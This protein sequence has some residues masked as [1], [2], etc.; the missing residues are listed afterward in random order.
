MSNMSRH[1]MGRVRPPVRTLA[2]AQVRCTACM[3]SSA[4]RPMAAGAAA[5]TSLR[6]RRRDGRPPR[7]GGSSRHH[8]GGVRGAGAHTA[9]APSVTSDSPKSELLMAS[10]AEA[11]AAAGHPLAGPRPDREP[12]EAALRGSQGG[13][14][15]RVYETGGATQVSRGTPNPAGLPA[16]L[17]PGSGV[18]R[19]RGKE[20]PARLRGPRLVRAPPLGRG[21]PRGPPGR[22][23]D[24][25]VSER[26]R[27]QTRVAP[28]SAARRVS[29]GNSTR[30]GRGRP[31]GRTETN[32]VG[33]HPDAAVSSQR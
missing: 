29:A 7:P 8:A 22:S 24:S 6:T 15:R 30:P 4:A 12:G 25:P 20:T 11:F 9:G 16:A 5:E 19:H 13:D 33:G 31:H 1:C 23:L 27:T 2:L 18:K 21:Q 14:A 28:G 32:S 26:P 17:T 10:A 3:T